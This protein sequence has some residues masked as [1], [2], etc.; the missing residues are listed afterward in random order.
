MIVKSITRQ[1]EIEGCVSKN[2]GARSMCLKHWGRW[3]NHADPFWGDHKVLTRSI[4]NSLEERFWSRVDKTAPRQPHM[5]T[6]YWE[7][8]G[9]P[10]HKYGEISYQGM[11]YLAHKLGY[12][13]VYGKM[14]DGMPA[15]HR[16]D[17]TRCV[18]PDHIFEGTSLDN[19]RD[20]NA[21][22]RGNYVRPYNQAQGERVNTAWG[23]IRFPRCTS[24]NLETRRMNDTQQTGLISASGEPL[25]IS[26]SMAIHPYD[27]VENWLKG[28][29][30]TPPWNEKQIAAFQKRLDSA[31]GAPNAFVLGWAPDRTYGDAFLNDIGELEKK[32]LLL[33]AEAPTGPT[34]YLYVVPPRWVILEVHHGSQ[35]EA[36]WE[37]DSWVEY[38]GVKRRVRAE[39]PPEFFYVPVR[40]I[41]KHET[42]TIVGA[43]APCC[44]RLRDAGSLCF[45]LY[46]E[47]AESDIAYVRGVRAS[48]DKANIVQRNDAARSEKII[49]DS[50]A[51]TKHYMQRSAELQS[52]AVQEMM[53]AEPEKF[54]GDMLKNRGATMSARELDTTVRRALEQQ[55]EERF[56]KV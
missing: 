8:V 25:G 48:L 18:R 47:P 5:E 11:K 36:S 49:K 50:H 22:G 40:T 7:W 13:L 38:E 28:D 27:D 16:C 34:S 56:E 52:I 29:C 33:L 6:N 54:F 4:G 42:S 15:C 2:H 12:E 9:M 14:A 30:K 31:F 51:R 37:A 1:C 53:L 10:S 39:K 46:R 23:F 24:S 41:A 19:M 35:L 21:K 45:G 32:P 17:N 55:H 44:Q 20:K 3:R 43:R 26:P